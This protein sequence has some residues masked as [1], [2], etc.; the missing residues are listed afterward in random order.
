MSKPAY[1]ALKFLR[2][3]VTILVILVLFLFVFLVV[4][5]TIPF[6][7]AETYEKNE[8]PHSQFRVIVE[9]NDPFND[10]RILRLVRWDEFV[11]SRETEK[12]KIYRSKAEGNCTDISFWCRAESIEPHKQIIALRYGQENFY[13]FNRYSVID[14]QIHPLYCR[15]IDPGHAMMGVFLSFILTPIILALFHLGVRR[16]KRR[17]SI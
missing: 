2:V 13:I 17:K 11:A 14:D 6:L 10:Q 15:I 16:Y 7:T 12:Y 8:T 5:F 4:T 3:I 1:L 9:V